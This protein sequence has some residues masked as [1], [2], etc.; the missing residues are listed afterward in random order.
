[1]GPNGA[2]KT[3][4]MCAVFG[5]VELDTGAVSWRNQPITPAARARFGYMPEERGL[6]P[7]CGGL[8]P[9]LP[10]RRDLPW[11]RRDT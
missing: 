9:E 4:A 7:A 2:I 8:H 5:L 11:I 10:C 3:T 6:Y 1:L